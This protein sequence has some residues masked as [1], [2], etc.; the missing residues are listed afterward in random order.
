MIVAVLEILLP[1]VIALYLIFSLALCGDDALDA[2]I[3]ESMD[4]IIVVAIA[5]FVAVTLTWLIVPQPTLVKCAEMQ[6]LWLAPSLFWT[7]A[8]L[9]ISR[10]RGRSGKKTW[11]LVR[12][13]LAF[14]L[15]F[16]LG[17]GLS[18]LAA[19]VLVQMLLLPPREL[20][21]PFA[22]TVPVGEWIERLLP[23]LTTFHGRMDGWAWNRVLF[24]IAGAILMWA[25]CRRIEWSSPG[26]RGAVRRL[27]VPVVSVF[28]LST[29]LV[30]LGW[31]SDC[32]G[33]RLGWCEGRIEVPLDARAHSGGTLR[34]SYLVKPATGVRRPDGVVV[35]AIG[36]PSAG[37]ASR[38]VLANAL[39]DIG[40]RRD[41]LVSD[42]RGFGRS[43]RVGCAGMRIGAAEAGAV[44]G[45]FDGLGPLAA[46]LSARHASDDLEAVR[47]TLRIER[48]DIYG[49]SYGTFFAQTYAQMYPSSVRSMI[50]DS[51]L[52]LHGSPDYTFMVSKLVGEN[53]SPERDSGTGSSDAWRR[54]VE[55]ARN[56]N[57]Q[58]PDIHTLA[59]IHF[60]SIWP[61][62]EQEKVEALQLPQDRRKEVLAALGARLQARVRAMQDDPIASLVPPDVTAAYACNDYSM[63][64][65]RGTASLERERATRSYARENFTSNIA[66]F[67]WDEI[68]E[69]SRITNGL[70]VDSFIYEA[71]L[72]WDYSD[73]E[74]ADW[75]EPPP[76]D[77][78]VISGSKDFTT[79]PE[80]AREIAESWT[81]ARVVNVVGGDH[82]VLVN[83]TNICARNAALEFILNPDA[84]VPVECV[85]EP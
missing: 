66:P 2:R 41:I 12:H 4:R 8:A 63:P 76:I 52:P 61:E 18:W 33:W 59:V 13:V 19:H 7:G 14:V 71:C 47:R 24:F 57:W 28:A 5:A 25:S 16:A 69:A 20:S 39:G 67:T 9:L 51:A 68:N 38:F 35:A 17:T 49:Q 3:R 31:P 78:L 74:P 42:Y 58:D 54:I 62:V 46:R 80:M 85:E 60:F 11:R 65:Q 43:G 50:L 40:A 48:W 44:K 56:G 22:A 72:F 10:W 70:Q 37:S 77:V 23:A 15:L 21:W 82:F 64:F 30:S 79:T 53:G 32:M 84:Y 55:E 26:H 34:I 27:A 6:L 36:G 81:K 1:L 73:S 75:P 29:S 45:C 83:P